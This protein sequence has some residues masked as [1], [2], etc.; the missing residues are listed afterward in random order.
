MPEYKVLE[1]ADL[2]VLLAVFV[3]FLFHCL[4]PFC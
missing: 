2:D 4:F 1:A 3:D